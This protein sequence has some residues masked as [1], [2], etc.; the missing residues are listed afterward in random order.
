MAAVV[1]AH[2]VRGSSA[3]AHVILVLV[4]SASAQ[5]QT[6]AGWPVST[7]EGQGLAAAPLMRLDSAIATGH[8]GHVDR[9]VVV[10][11]ERVVLNR[12]YALAGSDVGGSADNAIRHRMA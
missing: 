7:P 2:K 3:I 12:R 5:A 9:L 8:Y 1:N 10:R 11:N 4:L 6:T